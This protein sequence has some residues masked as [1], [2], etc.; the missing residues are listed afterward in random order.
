MSKSK[1]FLVKQAGVLKIKPGR[2]YGRVFVDLV[3]AHGLNAVR[4]PKNYDLVVQNQARA[5]IFP[6]HKTVQQ[7][8]RGRQGRILR[9]A[10]CH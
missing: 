5:N 7:L 10:P 2:W 4:I 6:D 9:D 1:L 3:D 8:S